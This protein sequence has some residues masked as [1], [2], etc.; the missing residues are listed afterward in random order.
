MPK[1]AVQSILEA[2]KKSGTKTKTRI[3][4]CFVVVDVVVAIVVDVRQTD[5]VKLVRLRKAKAMRPTSDQFQLINYG[6]PEHLNQKS[7]TV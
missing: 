7:K 1:E 3:K 4:T 5:V 6:R 2:I